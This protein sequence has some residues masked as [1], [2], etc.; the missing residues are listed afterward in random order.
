MS[1]AIPVMAERVAL[2]P[3]DNLFGDFLKESGKMDVD[4]RIEPARTRK[5]RPQK[6]SRTKENAGGGPVAKAADKALLDADAALNSLRYYGQHTQ[7]SQLAL[8]ST[9]EAIMPF[10]E[11]TQQL[12]D[13][14]LEAALVNLEEA[15]V[16]DY[17]RAIEIVWKRGLAHGAWLREGEVRANQEA[18]SAAALLRKKVNELEEQNSLLQR[19]YTEAAAEIMKLKVQTQ[20]PIEEMQM[21]DDEIKLEEMEGFLN[22]LFNDDVDL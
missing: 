17:R 20:Q 7:R 6:T 11:T 8:R 10:M 16:A 18:Q 9:K 19:L 13:S 2:A 14:V 21:H 12:D 3:L 15:F 4:P 22:S 5:S 1:A